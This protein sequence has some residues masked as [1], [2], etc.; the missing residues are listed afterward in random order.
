MVVSALGHVMVASLV[1]F[2][3]QYAGMEVKSSGNT[4]SVNLEQSEKAYE[5]M[6]TPF[7]I[8]AA[9]RAEQPEKAYEPIEV[10]EFGKS[11]DEILPQ[12]WKA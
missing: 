12:F 3:K 6:E 8:V 7:P 10:S 1:Q 9:L 5:P 4:M 2:W 11:M